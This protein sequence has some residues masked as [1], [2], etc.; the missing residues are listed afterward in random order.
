MGKDLLRLLSKKLGVAGTAIAVVV[1][2]PTTPP[3]KGVIVGAIAIVYII[4]QAFVDHGKDKMEV[5]MAVIEKS[6]Q[7]GK[8]LAGVAAKTGIDPGVDPRMN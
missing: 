4:A 5:Q 8:D 3:V 1:T 7:L 6:A 2:L